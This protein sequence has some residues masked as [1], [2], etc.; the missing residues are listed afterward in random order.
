M[1]QPAPV[2]RTCSAAAATAAAAEAEAGADGVLTVEGDA[3]RRAGRR[4]V[5]AGQQA[6]PGRRRLVVE[7]YR[8]PG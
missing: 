7:R 8:R 4:G 6:I 1:A 5:A 3:A 2:R